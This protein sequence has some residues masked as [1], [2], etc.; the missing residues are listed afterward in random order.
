MKPGRNSGRNAPPSCVNEFFNVSDGSVVSI[1]VEKEHVI[2]PH[3]GDDKGA[4]TR[5]A[6]RGAGLEVTGL[7]DG[8]EEQLNR[9]AAI[10]IQGMFPRVRIHR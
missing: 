1:V 2:E 5:Q 6:F 10:G 7:A 9:F 8:V 3:T 4:R